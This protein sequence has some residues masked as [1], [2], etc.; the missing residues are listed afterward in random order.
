MC[1]NYGGTLN[2]KVD[3]NKING[4][5]SATQYRDANCSGS[6]VSYISTGQI[7]QCGG[8]TAWACYWEGAGSYLPSSAWIIK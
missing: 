7:G 2:D 4:A 5:R 1:V 8:A 6:T 3:S